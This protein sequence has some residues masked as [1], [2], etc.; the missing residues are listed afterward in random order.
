MVVGLLYVLAAG[1]LAMAHLPTKILFFVVGGI[2]GFACGGYDT[3][4]VVWVLEM[5][6]GEAGIW[7]QTQ[8]FFLRCRKPHRSA[9]H[10]TILNGGKCPKWHHDNHRFMQ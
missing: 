10:E 9:P 2:I 7:V 1:T 6:S 3:S 4:Q 5:W 8:Y